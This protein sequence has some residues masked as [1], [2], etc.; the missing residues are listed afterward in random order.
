[1]KLVDGNAAGQVEIVSAA[2]KERILLAM[3]G[4]RFGAVEIVIHDGKVVQIE[5]KERLRFDK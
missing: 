3:Q 2:I 4:I 1:M 5:R